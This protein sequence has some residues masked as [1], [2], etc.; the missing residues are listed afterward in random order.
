MRAVLVYSPE[1]YEHMNKS[2][3]K[4]W[5][6]TLPGFHYSCL[7]TTNR[8]LRIA[9]SRERQLTNLQAVLLIQ[10]HSFKCKMRLCTQNASGI[11]YWSLLCSCV[12]EAES[13]FWGSRNNL[14]FCNHCFIQLLFVML[15][16]S[17]PPLLFLLPL[18]HTHTY[19]E[20]MKRAIMAQ[21]WGELLACECLNSRA[22]Y[23]EPG[24]SM[25][26]R[27]PRGPG[28]GTCLTTPW[29]YSVSP[30]AWCRLAPTW[31][32]QGGLHLF[33]CVSSILHQSA[34]QQRKW[35]EGNLKCT[36]CWE[37]GKEEGD[38]GIQ[39][40]SLQVMFNVFTMKKRVLQ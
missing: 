39:T 36:K 5:G 10:W 16:Y 38:T 34:T 6:Q 24:G 13:E 21:R 19:T 8:F 17:L 33:N 25:V 27:L 20:Q 22:S 7:W 12:S 1:W 14:T 30:L 15:C 23:W 31:G 2:H 28:S 4:A 37:K 35:R 9:E 3:E 18:R 29:P 26:A 32:A 11:L 40:H